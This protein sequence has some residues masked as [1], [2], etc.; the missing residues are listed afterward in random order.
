MN[1]HQDLYVDVKGYA[2]RL[3][4]RTGS[5]K[6]RHQLEYEGFVGIAAYH[7]WDDIKIMMD[8]KFEQLTGGK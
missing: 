2:E 8:K 4:Q 1:D 7:E 6:T 5:E 3:A